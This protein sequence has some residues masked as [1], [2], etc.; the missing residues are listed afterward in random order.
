MEQ[1]INA[2]AHT[3]PLRLG[4]NLWEHFGYF[5][6]NSIPTAIAGFYFTLEFW[7]VSY[8]FRNTIPYLLFI[9]LYIYL[10]RTFVPYDFLFH[11]LLANLVLA[12]SLKMFEPRLSFLMITIG[13]FIINF[14]G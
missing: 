5:L 7:A 4:F 6:G 13:L 14:L 3:S 12:I 11:C 10:Q 8:R 9:A 2:L 1:Y